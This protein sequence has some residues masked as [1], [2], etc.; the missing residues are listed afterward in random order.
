MSKANGQSQ[1]W[2]SAQECL[3]VTNLSAGIALNAQSLVT[4][5]RDMCPDPLYY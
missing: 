4:Y 1:D 3:R 5:W 2:D